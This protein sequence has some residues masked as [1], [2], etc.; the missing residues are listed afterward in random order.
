MQIIYPKLTNYDIIRFHKVIIVSCIIIVII[1]ISIRIKYSKITSAREQDTA[2]IYFFFL[3]EK[4]IFNIRNFT[5]VKKSLTL[6]VRYVSL[7]FEN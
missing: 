1:K 7:R 6:I 5:K 3:L 2:G 4:K